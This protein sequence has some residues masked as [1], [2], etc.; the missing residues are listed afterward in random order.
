MSDPRSTVVVIL[1]PFRLS[2]VL[3]VLR[4][5]TLDVVG[6]H[7]TEVRGYG[8]QK[9]HLD[10]YQEETLATEF[11]PKIRIEFGVGQSKL[12]LVIERVSEA[13]ATGRIGDGKIFVFPP[14]VST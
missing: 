10:A 8:R 13:A 11:I 14:A 1:K 3:E 7:Y 6:V 12:P 5:A 4:D 2:Q 9:G